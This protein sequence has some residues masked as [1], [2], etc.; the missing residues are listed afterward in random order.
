LNRLTYST[1]ASSSWERVRL[2]DAI[3]DQPGL[4]GLDEA[5]GHRVVVAV[6][7]GP[8]RGQDAVVIEDLLEDL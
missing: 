1:I 4:E 3:A 7:D 6:A 8:D 2:P 5:L